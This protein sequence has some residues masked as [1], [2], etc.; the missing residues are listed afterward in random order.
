MGGRRVVTVL[1]EEGLFYCV[2]PV[3]RS[4][5]DIIRRLFH[6]LGGVL[7]RLFHIS[8]CSF[9]RTQ[10]FRLLQ[11]PSST[12]SDLRVLSTASI[13]GRTLVCPVGGK[14]CNEGKQT[15]EGP[16]GAE[17]SA[18]SCAK[19]KAAVATSPS[20]TNDSLNILE[21]NGKYRIGRWGC[22]WRDEG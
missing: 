15:P 19:V 22:D 2:V 12:C 6:F 11:L 4:L 17:D 13:C 9:I 21:G 8:I 7:T 3:F 1:S 18:G 16:A 20:R 5:R 10:R 14:L